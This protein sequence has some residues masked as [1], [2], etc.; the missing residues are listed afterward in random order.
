MVQHMRANATGD[1]RNY[2]LERHVGNRISVSE[3]QVFQT[4]STMCVAFLS[5]FE[6]GGDRPHKHWSRCT[7]IRRSILGADMSIIQ[8]CE[9]F[10]TKVPVELRT[11]HKTTQKASNTRVFHSTRSEI[12]LLRWPYSRASLPCRYQAPELYHLL[13]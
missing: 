6:H 12:R 13:K 5:A 8:N 2:D 3:R 10:N 1:T 4:L 9:L 11:A 7:I